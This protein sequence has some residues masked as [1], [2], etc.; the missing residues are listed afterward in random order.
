[1]LDLGMLK[2]AAGVDMDAFAVHDL[3]DFFFAEDG[4]L[5]L[6]DVDDAVG[7]DMG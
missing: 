1:M 5:L 7:A 4:F 2:R 6:D 3:D